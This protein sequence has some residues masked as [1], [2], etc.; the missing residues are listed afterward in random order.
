MLNLDNYIYISN[1]LQPYDLIQLFSINHEFREIYD[2]G[3]IFANSLHYHIKELTLLTISKKCDFFILWKEI[4]YKRKLLQTNIKDIPLSILY[5]IF[6]I[7]MNKLTYEY[8]AFA[9]S[10]PLIINQSKLIGRLNYVIDKVNVPIFNLLIKRINNKEYFIIKIIENILNQ[11]EYSLLNQLIIDE[12]IIDNNNIII[13]KLNLVN[14]LPDDYMVFDKV[15]YVPNCEILLRLN[16]TFRKYYLSNLVGDC[17]CDEFILGLIRGN[18][19]E[20]LNDILKSGNYY[21]KNKDRIK[22]LLFSNRKF[23]HILELINFN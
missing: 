23:M 5:N 13:T 21:I 7:G 12:E 20:L 22:R 10:S 2:S 14:I 11:E 1:F 17:E 9:L 15:K 6:N 3:I 8:V 16:T 18:N 4:I 19:H